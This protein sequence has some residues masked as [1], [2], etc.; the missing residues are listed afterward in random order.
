MQYIKPGGT[1]PVPFNLIPMPH[2]FYMMF[3]HLR[4]LIK[5]KSGNSRHPT[6]TV[7]DDFPLRKANGHANR[8]EESHAPNVTFISAFA[9]QLAQVV[10]IKGQKSI[11]RNRGIDLSSMISALI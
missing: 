11:T 1:L 3:K 9:T 2:G 8:P 6:G 7:M 10:L 5:R 4:A